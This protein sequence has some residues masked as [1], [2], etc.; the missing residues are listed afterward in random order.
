MDIQN[1]ADYWENRLKKN[2]G[3]DGTGFIGLGINYNRWMYK[4]RRQVVIREVRSLGVDCS[5]AS[6]LD[7][8]SGTGFY[9]DI[10]KELGCKKLSGIDITSTAIENLAHKIPSIRILESRY[11]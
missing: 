2:Y 3:L 7:V 8:G 1:P 9:L 6:I 5:H 10:W 11:W 4:I